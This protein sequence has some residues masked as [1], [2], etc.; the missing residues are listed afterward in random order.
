MGADERP[1]LKYYD[2]A[3]ADVVVPD[4]TMYEWLRDTATAYPDNTAVLFLGTKMTF[5]RLMREVN[6]CAAALVAQGVGCG[7]SVLISLPNIPNVVIMFYAL[8]KIGAR[9]VMT[10]PLSSGDELRHYAM[11][12]GARWAF[13][14]DMFFDRL[15]ALLDVPGLR[16][17]YICHIFDYLGA[18]MT[19]G[20]K[21]TK[22]RGTAPLPKDDALIPWTDFMKSAGDQAP[23]ERR[24]DPKEGSAVLFS[25]GTTSLPKGIELSSRAFNALAASMIELIHI[26]PDAEKQLPETMARAREDGVLTAAD[27]IPELAGLIGC[28]R[29]ALERTVLEY[30][31]FCAH[32]RDALFA[33]RRRDLIALGR[34]PY[35]A[36]R[37]GADMLVTH[38][39]VR[40]NERFEALRDS[41]EP[42]PN[43]YVAGVDFGG[44]DADVYNVAMSGHGFGFAVNSG[45]IAGEN[46]ARALENAGPKTT[47]E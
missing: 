37:A 45:R 27:T 17:L 47:R 29:D 16:R 32:N 5:G 26:A 34:P 22:G 33:K 10:H 11:E 38:G 25:G 4:K 30:N 7:D 24:L 9:A 8:N 18:A 20:F 1:W 13:G 44:A 2:G 23:Y 12:T 15:K 3:D 21:L 36:V 40:V 43:L 42:V 35:Y 46:A 19:V 28:P 6:R 39:G 31:S 14:V 41:F